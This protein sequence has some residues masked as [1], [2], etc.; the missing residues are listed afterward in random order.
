MKTRSTLKLAASLAF[1]GFVQTLALAANLVALD[2]NADPH[3]RPAMEHFSSDDA[4][5][6]SQIVEAQGTIDT[7]RGER[8]GAAACSLRIA[9]SPGPVMT[10]PSPSIGLSTPRH[11]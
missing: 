8:S 11:V 4:V 3:A 6:A 7:F 5:K 10:S 1:A 2:F 9:A